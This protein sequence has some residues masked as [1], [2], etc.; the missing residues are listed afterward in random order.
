MKVI[1]TYNADNLLETLLEQEWEQGWVNRSRRN[2]EYST[3]DLPQTITDQ[4]WDNSSQTFINVQLTESSYTIDLE[5]ETRLISFWN[6][7]TNSWDISRKTEYS[8]NN[9]GLLSNTSMFS[10]VDSDWIET[11]HSETEYDSNNNLIRQS[12]YAL[13]SY[14]EWVWAAQEL[15]E[16]DGNNNRTRR[17]RQIW[18]I[19]EQTFINNSR[20]DYFF[21][22]QDIMLDVADHKNIQLKVSPNPSRGVFNITTESMSTS[23]LNIKVTDISGRN[24]LTT[25]TSGSNHTIDLSNQASGLY[26]LY[27]NDAIPQKIVLK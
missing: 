3:D 16:F 5:I 10:W 18:D 20:T 13:D 21:S 26:F 6:T 9:S 23:N 7:T 15:F 19:Y 25:T 24:I 4:D 1:N 8:Y 17:T 2:F 12:D 14:G 11:N 27:V 22:L